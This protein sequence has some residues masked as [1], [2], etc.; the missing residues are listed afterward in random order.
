LAR[1]GAAVGEVNGLAG[2]DGR[3]AATRDDAV[4]AAADV[5]RVGD[6][7]SDVFPVVGVGD[8]DG[9][10]ELP[11]RVIEAVG[12]HGD[13]VV[14]G[15]GVAL[16]D[17]DLGLVD[18]LDDRPLVG[19]VVGGR[20]RLGDRQVLAHADLDGLGVVLTGLIDDRGVGVALA[21]AGDTLLVQRVGEVM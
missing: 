11:V 12:R 10:A 9:A 19:A 15:G 14:E 3:T 2:R 5:H 6:V 17:V 16:G 18:L 8:R 21:G 4:R 1:E 7:G 13:R 20:G